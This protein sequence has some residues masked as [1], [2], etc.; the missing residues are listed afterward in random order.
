MKVGIPRHEL[1]LKFN[2]RI[3]HGIYEKFVLTAMSFGCPYSCIFCPMQRLV[4]KERDIEEV[5][6]EM[7][8]IS[9]IGI[10]EVFFF[11]QTFAYN[12]EDTLIFCEKMI[13]E[14]LQIKWIC[15]SRVDVVDKE[16]LDLMKKAG[17]HTI[18]FGVE[19]ADEDI[20]KAIR[21]G[22]S[23]DKCYKIFNYCKE[24]G[25]KTLGHFI[26][27]LPGENFESV[28]ATVDYAIQL[29][30][31]YASFNIAEA[32]LGTNLRD[33]AVKKGLI[34]CSKQASFLAFQAY[35]PE[36]LSFEQL[37][38][39]RDYAV[40]KFYFRPTY[41]LKKLFFVRSFYELKNNFREGIGL[42]NS[43]LGKFSYKRRIG[44]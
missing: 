31:D 12:R 19:S 2:Y 16:L 25:I 44:K 7:R 5:M 33:E 41:I 14:N 24:I 43:V 42:L 34:D 36:G 9:S 4:Y 22:L 39:W 23:T 18:Q 1:F 32:P 20:L 21:K 10:K 29:G 17:C 26:I 3:P 35:V 37:V 28:K 6:E 40:K 13:N 11:D 30:C 38:E 8:Y 15:M 27:G